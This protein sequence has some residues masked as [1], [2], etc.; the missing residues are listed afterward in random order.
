[1]VWRL[2]KI[3]GQHLRY[4]KAERVREEGISGVGMVVG[5]GKIYARTLL[6]RSENCDIKKNT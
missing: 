1:M 5:V 6:K 2:Y 3:L 4:Y